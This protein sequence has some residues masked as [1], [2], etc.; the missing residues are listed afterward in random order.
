MNK[1]LIKKYITQTL[2]QGEDP[3]EALANVLHIALSGDSQQAKALIL[4]T[5]IEL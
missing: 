3:L 4:E 1:N 5:L 2:E